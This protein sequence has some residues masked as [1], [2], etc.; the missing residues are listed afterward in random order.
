M[1]DRQS[2]STRLCCLAPILGRSAIPIKN[3]WGVSHSDFGWLLLPP[4][5]LNMVS[6]LLF[7][8]AE[9]TSLMVAEYDRRDNSYYVSSMFTRAVDCF[10]ERV[11]RIELNP[12]SPFFLIFYF[13][14][15]LIFMVSAGSR[16]I[17]N[18]ISHPE[19]SPGTPLTPI[20]QLNHS[21]STYP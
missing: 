7:F 18:L 15:T 21:L 12:P 11:L 3:Y 10:W 17:R 20:N 1:T 16:L 8:A 2:Q 5:T 14:G 4:P 9:I 13:W 6:F 19:I